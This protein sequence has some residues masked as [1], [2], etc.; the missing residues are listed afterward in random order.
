VHRLQ[1]LRLHDVPQL[2]HIANG[3][4]KMSEANLQPP[5][6]QTPTTDGY[7]ASSLVVAPLPDEMGFPLRE[8]QFQTLCDGSSSDAK[9][10]IYLCIGL[11]A[12]AVVGVFSL[13][14]NADWA[15]FWANKRGMLLIYFAVLLVIAAGSLAGLVICGL[16]LRKENTPYSRLKTKIERYFK[17]PPP[18]G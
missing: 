3:E 12:S 4:A 14:E 8:D 9:S 6:I 10:G 7:H 18:Q 2:G 15:S 13:F 16:R 17:N 5:V 1:E 11:F